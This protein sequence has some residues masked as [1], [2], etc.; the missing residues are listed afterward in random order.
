MKLASILLVA[1]ASVFSGCIP[2]R[3]QTL[4]QGPS[5]VDL[6]LCDDSYL[7]V[8][9]G[10]STEPNRHKILPGE[11]YIQ[12]PANKRYTIQV[13]PHPFDIEQKHTNVRDE[14]YLCEADG[15]RLKRWSNGIWLVHFVVQTNGESRVIDQQ[16]KFWT[17]YYSPF[18]HGPP[19]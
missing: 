3:Q 18:I 12:S 6:L 5:D 17:F 13:F 2:L 14:V 7:L 11:S 4:V 8:Q 1:L 9:I 15:S 10:L 16:L 19:N